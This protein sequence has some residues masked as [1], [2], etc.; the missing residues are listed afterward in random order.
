L[1]L[2]LIPWGLHFGWLCSAVGGAVAV[3]LCFASERR[4]YLK[5]V[6]R[7]RRVGTGVPVA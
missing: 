7:A 1:A 3:V 2:I 5:E 4:I 6:R